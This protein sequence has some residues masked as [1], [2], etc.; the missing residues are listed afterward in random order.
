M[1]EALKTLR[2]L[3]PE[4]KALLESKRLEGEY[5]PYLRPLVKDGQVWLFEIV[6]WP[7]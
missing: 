1:F 5:A 6:G 4:Q 3:S 7:R 2:S